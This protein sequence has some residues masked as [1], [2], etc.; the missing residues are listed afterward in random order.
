MQTAST[1]NL[2]PAR[3]EFSE[4]KGILERASSG[5]FAPIPRA[6][7]IDPEEHQDA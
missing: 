5:K 1:A 3:F 6:N 7:N 4:S 2:D